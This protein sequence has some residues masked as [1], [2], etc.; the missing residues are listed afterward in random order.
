MTV[1]KKHKDSI[2][3]ALFSNPDTLRE[4]YCDITRV[5]FIFQNLTRRHGG[6][7]ATEKNK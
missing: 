3:T 7:A 5:E 6:T 2:F 4:L 1:N